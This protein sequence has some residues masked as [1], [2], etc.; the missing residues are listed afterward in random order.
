MEIVIGEGAI[1]VAFGASDWVM[2]YGGAQ[3]WISF[4]GVWRWRVTVGLC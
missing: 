1:A 2:I 4:A 3:C